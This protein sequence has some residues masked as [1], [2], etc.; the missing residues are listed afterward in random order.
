MTDIKL[1]P[2][3]HAAPL[4]NI[5]LG[6]RQALEAGDCVIF[7]GAGM[8]F[9][10]WRASQQAPDASTLAQELAEHFKINGGDKPELPRFPAS[11]N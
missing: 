6:L 3:G 5:P 9:H 11:W 4:P 10:L 2:P 7:I 8:G 1:D